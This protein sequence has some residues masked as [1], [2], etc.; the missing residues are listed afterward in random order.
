MSYGNR[1]LPRSRESG[2]EANYLFEWLQALV[3][4]LSLLDNQDKLLVPL[5][6]LVTERY[7]KPVRSKIYVLTAKKRTVI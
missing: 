6:K 3:P 1:T 5:V 4:D 2:D 7:C